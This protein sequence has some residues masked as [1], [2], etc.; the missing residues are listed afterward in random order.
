MTYYTSKRHRDWRN[1]VLRAAKYKCVECA[2]YGINR[3]ATIAHHIKPRELYPEYQYRVD[4]G[5][6]LCGPCHNKHHPEKGGA[7][8]PV[9]R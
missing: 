6:A 9:D 8:P 4:N 5:A 3:T 1:K 2:R 7:R